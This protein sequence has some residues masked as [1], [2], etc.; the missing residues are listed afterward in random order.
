MIVR[1]LAQMWDDH[2]I[3]KL[4]TTAGPLMGQ[5]GLPHPIS[6]SQ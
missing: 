6:V 1:A 2:K 3:D 4:I 5:F